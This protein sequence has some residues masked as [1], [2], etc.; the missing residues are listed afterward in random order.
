MS[1]YKKDGLELL[2]KYV[3]VFTFVLS[4]M[5]SSSTL[6]MSMSEPINIGEIYST[7][8]Y[9]GFEFSGENENVVYE[10]RP[11]K[12]GRGSNI[13]Y[14]GRG[15]TNWGYGNQKLYCRWNTDY[16]GKCNGAD[17]S[18]CWLSGANKNY[19]VALPLYTTGIELSVI[20]S[21]INTRLYLC[22][23]LINGK[24]VCSRYVLLGVRADGVAMKYFD[25][26]DVL[27]NMYGSSNYSNG[28]FRPVC[29]ENSAIVNGDKIIIPLIHTM[30]NNGKYQSTTSNLIFTWDE[31]AQ[32]FGVANDS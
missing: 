9:G 26:E 13:G 27:Q 2:I 5:V 8:A 28:Y 31:N 11:N 23:Y 12:N 15:I 10:T 16:Q 19:G 30:Y 17:N 18:G 24:Q 29:K 6:A 3:T 22:C 14:W 32:W 25:T 20:P 4:M 7:G 21:D 1:R